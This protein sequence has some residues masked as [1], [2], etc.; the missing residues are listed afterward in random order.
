MS[1]VYAGRRSLCS[2]GAA[3]L[4]EEVESFLALHNEVR[5]HEALAFKPPLHAHRSDQHLFG[6]STLRER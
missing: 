5:P 1:A 2:T 4:A 3:E 6:A